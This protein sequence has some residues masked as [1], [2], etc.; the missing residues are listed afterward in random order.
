MREFDKE[1]ATL[2]VEIILKMKNIMGNV[3][4]EKLELEFE[5]NEISG[6]WYLK[7]RKTYFQ[8]K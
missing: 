6:M 4:T 2:N 1:K 5:R 8:F 7:R 3:Y